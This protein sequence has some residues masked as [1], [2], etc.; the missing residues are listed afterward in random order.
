[1]IDKWPSNILGSSTIRRPIKNQV[2]AIGV[3]KAV[4]LDMEDDAFKVE[5]HKVFPDA[6]FERMSKGPEKKALR[7]IKIDFKRKEDLGKAI[8]QGI[9]LNSVYQHVTVEKLIW[10]PHVRHCKKC[11]RIG[12]TTEKCSDNERCE[13]CGLLKNEGGHLACSEN[14]RCINCKGAH[15]ASLTGQCPKYLNMLNLINQR[16]AQHNQGKS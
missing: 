12:H 1:M 14:P 15:K 11:W 6:K 7:T 4:P 13:H 5:L 8:E 10:S 3:A 2:K 16:H 9:I